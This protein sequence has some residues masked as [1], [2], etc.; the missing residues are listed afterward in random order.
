MRCH[1]I[2]LSP[3]GIMGLGTLSDT[4]RIR[5]PRPPQNSTVFI[6]ATFG[7]WYGVMTRSDPNVLARTKRAIL[8]PRCMV[9]ALDSNR[10]KHHS[11]GATRIL[12]RW[13][14]DPCAQGLRL[15]S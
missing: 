14:V 7:R 4:S 6:L 12:E 5:V 9:I 8:R 11:R 3:I 1:R 10:A 13:R 2:G 15:W